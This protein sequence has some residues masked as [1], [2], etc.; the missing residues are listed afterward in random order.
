ME[1]PRIDKLVT[2]P[3]AGVS[4][5]A[6]RAGLPPFPQLPGLN[7]REVIRGLSALRAETTP[8]RDPGLTE[9]ETATYRLR[10]AGRHTGELTMRVKPSKTRY[11]HEIEGELI[12]G[13]GIYAKSVMGRKDGLL[14]AQSSLLEGRVHGSMV[15][16]IE[17]RFAGIQPLVIGGETFEVPES[18]VPAVA[19]PLALR[20]GLRVGAKK[21]VPVA[22]AGAAA[23]ELRADVERIEP[24]GVPAGARQGYRVRF[25]PH[26]GNIPGQLGA[27]ARQLDAL[28]WRILP[29]FVAHF[30]VE[31]PHQLMRMEFPVGPLRWNSKGE[32]ELHIGLPFTER[33]ILEATALRTGGP[34]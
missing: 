32:I 21:V 34:G 18:V 23:V 2:A 6:E 31:P 5:L 12:D 8:C 24:V 11:V 10:L 25:R 33:G 4:G 22:I 29:P 13:A 28:V 3:L 7:N 16:R 27:F 9:A 19:L 30:A 20:G 1:L 26:L 15:T 17:G 14:L